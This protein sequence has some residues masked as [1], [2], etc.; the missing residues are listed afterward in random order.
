M[1]AP[2]SPATRPA[3]VGIQLTGHHE[4]LLPLLHAAVAGRLTAPRLEHSAQAA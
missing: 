4:V 3:A 1:P 2:R